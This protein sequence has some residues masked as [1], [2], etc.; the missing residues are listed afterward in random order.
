MQSQ[1]SST[2]GGDI[3]N[4]SEH[5]DIEGADD[6]WKSV[7]NSQSA[8]DAALRTDFS[9]DLISKPAGLS[10]RSPHSS[11]H[12]PTINDSPRILYRNPSRHLRPTHLNARIQRSVQNR[13]CLSLINH[14]NRLLKSNCA[15]CP[16]PSNYSHRPRRKDP[17]I[18]AQRTALAPMTLCNS[19]V[20]FL[21]QWKSLQ[22]EMKILQA[23]Q[24]SH[25]K[26]QSV[27]V[28]FSRTR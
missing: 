6:V 19:K 28:L 20:P 18:R 13:Q 9:K 21:A 16:P 24:T 3:D 26:F 10:V 15:K 7:S 8:T 17:N 2:T 25:C 23:T 4:A 11:Q 1:D 14:I 5:L 22:R 27:I 12:R